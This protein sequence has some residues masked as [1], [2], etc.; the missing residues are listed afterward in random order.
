MCFFLQ[1]GR[2][3]GI[4]DILDILDILGGDGNGN[5][6]GNGNGDRFVDVFIYFEIN[7]F[8]PFLQYIHADRDTRNMISP[9][10]LKRED[11][12]TKMVHSEAPCLFQRIIP[13]A[14][15]KTFARNVS[16]LYTFYIFDCHTI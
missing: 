13:E 11:K 9:N 6:I 8:Q 15:S 14:N 10:F 1:R 3:R 2:T 5:G 12:N 7:I 4:E 16:H